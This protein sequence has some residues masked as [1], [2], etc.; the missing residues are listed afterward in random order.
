MKNFIAPLFFVYFTSL[1][2]IPDANA[3]SCTIS[4]LSTA[5]P[6]ISWNH[7]D[8]TTDI[9]MSIYNPENCNAPTGSY[10]TN[11]S[12][13]FN[14]YSN[15]Q[16]L[17]EGL[18]HAEY[19]LQIRPQGHPAQEVVAIVNSNGHHQ[20]GAHTTTSAFNGL[21]PSKA[22][23]N[24]LLQPRNA[25]G[26]EQCARATA[27]P[28]KNFMLATYSITFTYRE[29]EFAPE[30]IVKARS[31]AHYDE[32]IIVSFG[33]PARATFFEWEIRGASGYMDQ[34]TNTESGHTFT[35]LSADTYYI[36]V[37]ACNEYGCSDERNFTRTINTVP[38]PPMGAHLH[39]NFVTGA[40]EV[41]WYY[42]SHSLVYS[43]ILEYRP[44]GGT[45]IRRRIIND[46]SLHQTRQIGFTQGLS[47]EARIKSCNQQGL[48]SDWEYA[49]HN[50]NTY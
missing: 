38:K 2:F 26:S 50:S 34:F 30:N 47:Y 21:D 19:A 42:Y 20:I 12:F 3:H 25:A 8:R 7:K 4:R 37:S 43:S 29:H 6:P 40:M 5:S 46:S 9:K 31:S 14:L 17:T 41:T 13:A 10:I 33:R 48:C 32:D 35:G 49:T 11:T 16:V 1:L 24:T 23:F 45:W 27:G 39:Y 44:L 18:L 36:T 22:N 15:R 28:C